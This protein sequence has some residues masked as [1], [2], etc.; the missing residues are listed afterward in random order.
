MTHTELYDR[1]AAAHADWL[2]CEID[3]E[4]ALAAAGHFREKVS[5]AVYRAYQTACEVKRA[6]GEELKA[7]GENV[8]FIDLILE[9]WDEDTARAVTA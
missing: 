7:A 3:Y 5:T 2:R 6:I 9:G 4:A 8:L 1:Y